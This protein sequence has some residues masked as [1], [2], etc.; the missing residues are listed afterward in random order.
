M[1]SVRE[2]QVYYSGHGPARYLGK[3]FGIGFSEFFFLFSVGS[4]LLLI[5]TSAF[6]L[7]LLKLVLYLLLLSFVDVFGVVYPFIRPGH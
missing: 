3:E 1:Q 2:K 6:E 5:N 4:V 7:F